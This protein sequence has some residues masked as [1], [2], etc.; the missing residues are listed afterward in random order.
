MLSLHLS[1]WLEW[2]CKSEAQLVGF[3]SKA[4]ESLGSALTWIFM[5]MEDISWGLSIQ[6]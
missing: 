6:R 4:V 5:S 2:K 1:K 3:L